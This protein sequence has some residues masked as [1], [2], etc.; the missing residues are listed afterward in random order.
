MWAFEPMSTYHYKL[1]YCSLL[2]ECHVW[3]DD[4]RTFFVI[5]VE[6]ILLNQE[7]FS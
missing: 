2:C 3:L 6:T 1:L 5:H 7:A 4:S